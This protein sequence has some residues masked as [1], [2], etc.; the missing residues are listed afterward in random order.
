MKATLRFTLPLL[1]CLSPEVASDS[2]SIDALSASPE[3]F[4][5]LLENEHVRV[6]EYTLQ[7]GEKDKPH[8]HPPKVSYIVEGGSLRI[9]TGGGKSF[10]VDESVGHAMWSEEIGEHFVENIGPTPVKVVLVE[11]KSATADK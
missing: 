10:V 9:T 8:T 6:L 4:K 7:P 1:L 11:V 2:T 3:N 5:L